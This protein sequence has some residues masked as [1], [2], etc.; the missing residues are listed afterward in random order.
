VFICSGVLQQPDGLTQALCPTE[1]RS[2]GTSSLEQSK[3][4][5][6]STG[7]QSP[8]PTSPGLRRRSS[9]QP[10]PRQLA[11]LQCSPNRPLP[12][13]QGAAQHADGASHAACRMA[14]NPVSSP[15][16]NRTLVEGGP[17]AQQRPRTAEPEQSPPPC[18]PTQL[19]EE[20]LL[21]TQVVVS[22]Q[23][24]TY[25]AADCVAQPAELELVLACSGG[26]QEP[27][28]G[29][30]RAAATASTGPQQPSTAAAEA[31]QPP[32]GVTAWILG[33]PVS[34]GPA[35]AAT[36]A[37]E[38]RPD[39]PNVFAMTPEA[40]PER[41]FVTEEAAVPNAGDHAPAASAAVGPAR[42]SSEAAGALAQEDSH[43]GPCRGED[44]PSDA[45]HMAES[46]CK[47]C[48][49]A[50]S[51]HRCTNGVQLPALDMPG[52]GGSERAQVNPQPEVVGCRPPVDA[53]PTSEPVLAEL[54]TA[55][56]LGQATPA[57]TADGAGYWAL[58][59]RCTAPQ[60]RAP[61]PDAASLELSAVPAAGILASCAAPGKR[62]SDTEVVELWRDTCENMD[63]GCEQS[64]VRYRTL[65]LD[66]SCAAKA[67]GVRLLDDPQVRLMACTLLRCC[68]VSNS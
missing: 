58:G 6:P 20:V 53:S 5:L 48:P 51:P 61:P 28:D 68:C 67:H 4:P 32:D 49:A 64:A 45:A 27:S 11:L 30:G 16:P 25:V 62:L 41:G 55:P 14:A 36:A 9:S 33:V 37:N 21:A 17:N 59:Q 50:A 24:D 15:S 23:V 46:P 38:Q 18:E 43:G 65:T 40:A 34:C 22:T 26:P 57:A 13:S 2:R 3:S 31:E 35:S 10:L 42:A 60:M 7:A 12:A 56:L 47:A 8:Q 29:A 52:E 1:P 54:A 44:T 63:A 39:E 66:V 19:Q